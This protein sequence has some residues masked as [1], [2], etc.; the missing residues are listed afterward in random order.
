MAFPA[1][2]IVKRGGRLPSQIPQ[3]REVKEI[4]KK[5]NTQFCSQ[6]PAVTR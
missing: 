5:K 4:S 3:L 1:V 6:D 2:S